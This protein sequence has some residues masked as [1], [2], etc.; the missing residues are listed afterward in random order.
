MRK[1]IACASLLDDCQNTCL[2]LAKILK[3][4]R[5][6]SDTSAFVSQ[7][8]IHYSQFTIHFFFRSFHRI[9][10]FFVFL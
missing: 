1:A 8:T 10:L 7:T 2:T 6:T 3:T 9:L 5:V 4:N